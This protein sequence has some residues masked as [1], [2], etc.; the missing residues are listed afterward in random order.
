MRIPVVRF[1]FGRIGHRRGAPARTR[2]D[3]RPRPAA[4]TTPR[5][6]RRRGGPRRASRPTSPRSEKRLAR[7]RGAFLSL[8]VTRREGG[9]PR[10]A[11]LRAHARGASVR[12]KSRRAVYAAPP[13]PRRRTTRAP[14]TQKR[15]ERHAQNQH[16]SYPWCAHGR[17]P[18]TTSE[19]R[20][21][22][23]MHP[24]LL[25]L[26]G[27]EPLH[28]GTHNNARTHDHENPQPRSR[29]CAED[30]RLA[31]LTWDKGLPGTRAIALAYD[32][33]MF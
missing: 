5:A 10:G 22:D 32:S 19:A 1:D 29:V 3:R 21:A 6:R 2:R 31:A 12:G 20:G 27:V 33:S 7:E 13:P 9:P 18:F 24:P 28:A 25:L 30:T 16:R 8:D 11:R 23:R 14:E 4:G 15:R 17:R 26:G